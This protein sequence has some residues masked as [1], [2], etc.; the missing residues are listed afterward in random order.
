M[1]AAR[2]RTPSLRRRTILRR[3]LIAGAAFASLGMASAAPPRPAYTVAVLGDGFAEALL[4]GLRAD[5][6]G[7][8]GTTVIEATHA[9]YGLADE[10]HLD[11]PR[12]VRALLAGQHVDAAVVMLGANDMTALPDQGTTAEP[13]GVR[14]RALYGDRV[15]AVADAFRQK[16]VPLVWV[17]L[18]IV[19]SDATAADFAELNEITRDRATDAGATYVDAWNAFADEAGRYSASGP[20][21]KGRIVRLR[22]ADGLDFTRAGAVKLA[23]LGEAGLRARRAKAEEP[24]VPTDI[25]LPGQGDF[26]AA[27]AIDV[28][29]QIRREAGLPAAPTAPGRTRRGPVIAITTP[30]LSPDGHLAEA[31]G[32]P[33]PLI[34]TGA[35]LAQ[36]ALVEGQ[37]LPPRAGRVDDF[38]WPRP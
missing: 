6:A 38:S 25:V 15:Q 12:T 37:P 22:E 33:A 4:E 24:A 32:D 20:D 11:W 30:P 23:G 14:W 18:P 27:L 26:D 9:P 8:P 36:R 31:S 34:G 17:G 21:A 13:H 1:T 7:Q 35:T 19:A 3:L 2:T 16:N 29:A 28:N 5:L 10:G